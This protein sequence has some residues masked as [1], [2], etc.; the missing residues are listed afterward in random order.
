MVVII[1][2]LLFCVVY[3]RLG[4]TK[5]TWNY[6]NSN[7]E[8]SIGCLYHIL[9]IDTNLLIENRWKIEKRGFV[10]FWLVSNINIDQEF[11]WY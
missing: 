5:N 4:L 8:C 2:K 3:H 9:A 6:S 11:E 1:C 7:T 10:A